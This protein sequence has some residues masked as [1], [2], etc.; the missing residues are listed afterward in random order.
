MNNNKKFIVIVGSIIAF[1]APLQALA[2]NIIRA[3]APV[4]L[5]KETELW[6]T[7]SS[8]YSEWLN[9]GAV[10]NCQ[11]W[12]PDT[13]A[14]PIGQLFVQTANDCEQ[15]QV[16]TVQ[17]REQS[18]KTQAYRDVG[19]PTT[20]LR[21]VNASLQR[22][23]VG[24]QES[25]MTASP[26]FTEWVNEGGIYECKTWSPDPST[27]AV[28]QAFTQTAND[29]KQNQ[30][31]TRQD[32]EQEVVTLEYRDIGD[33]VLESRIIAASQ[34]RASV[35][36]KETWIAAT[37]VYGAWANSGSVYG[38][39]N[40]SPDPSTVN[41]GVSFTQNATDC[42]IDQTRSKQDREQETTT[43]AY[44]NVGSV[45]TETQTLTGQASSR[46]AVGTKSARVCLYDDSFNPNYH[47]YYTNGSYA[48][49]WTN[50]YSSV[51]NLGIID[52]KTGLNAFGGPAIPGFSRVSNTEFRYND[53][54]K[55]WKISTGAYV[56]ALNGY[57]HYQVC[58]E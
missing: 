56:K 50:G 39:S 1:H 29:C 27:V 15:D 12:S 21:T 13:S 5:G 28:G 9:N 8:V 6:V 41:S 51:P 43:L 24:T 52:A 47:S 49:L 57:S 2:Q 45:Q 25:W 34:S 19:V 35:G 17:P 7:A 36:S 53:G 11:N 23:A 42:K 58:F 14:V 22:D 30:T 26:F 55:V 37:P 44:R 20:E 46:Q 38:C 18:T 3:Q 48:F 10:R 54:N 32:R 33:P 16:R 31:R 40:W 4:V